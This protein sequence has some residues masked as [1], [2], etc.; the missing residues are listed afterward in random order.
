L[1][2]AAIAAAVSDLTSEIVGKLTDRPWT[3]DVL[4]IEANRVF[5]SG[6][7]RQ[8]LKV[9]DRLAIET[10]GETVTSGQSGLP[11]T[12]PGEKLAEIEIVSFFGDSDYSEGSI[13][14]IVSGSVSPESP[15][16][17]VREIK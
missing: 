3:T 10:V 2:D 13:A 1:N 17:V 4:K 12:L 5:V 11:I 8:G 9:G 14:N 7:S 15:K 16:L 6:G